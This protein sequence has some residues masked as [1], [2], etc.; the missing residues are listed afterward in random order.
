METM[1]PCSVFKKKKPT[2]NHQCFPKGAKGIGQWG[3]IFS[4]SDVHKA[5][6]SCLEVVP[7][8]EIQDV[9]QK[10]KQK[11]VHSRI[12]NNHLKNDIQQ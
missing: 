12:A 10:F 4:C 3:K 2:R 8:E 11:N 7:R 5:A 9:R 1:F 6:I